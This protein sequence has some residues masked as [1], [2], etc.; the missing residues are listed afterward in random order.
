M[1]TLLSV[2]SLSEWQ[3]IMKW[4]NL[5][6]MPP[7]GH[8]KHCYIQCWYQSIVFN[9]EFK[10]QSLCPHHHAPSLTILASVRPFPW[11]MSSLF[12]PG[13]GA[14]ADNHVGGVSPTGHGEAIMKVTLSRLILFHM[15]QGTPILTRVHTELHCIHPPTS[16]RA[17]RCSV[18]SLHSPRPPPTSDSH[19]ARP[20]L[21]GLL[22]HGVHHACGTET[23]LGMDP[24]HGLFPGVRGRGATQVVWESQ[25]PAVFYLKGSWT[26]TFFFCSYRSV[27]HLIRTSS[28]NPLNSF[29]SSSEWCNES[30]KLSGLGLPLP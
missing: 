3:Y 22:R 7:G 14:Y 18:V 5:S 20:R 24:G 26:E 28:L 10:H 9:N 27:K 19:V 6:A 25:A 15:E 1:Q 4:F 2:L 16:P 17:L 23:K 8:K 13:C 11:V 21:V 30:W 12:S 29:F